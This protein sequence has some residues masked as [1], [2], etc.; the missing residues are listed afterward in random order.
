MGGKGTKQSNYRRYHPPSSPFHLVSGHVGINCGCTGTRK[1]S[2]H[3]RLSAPFPPP[4]LPP[5]HPNE[6][7]MRY[8]SGFAD[9]SPLKCLSIVSFCFIRLKTR[10]CRDAECY[11]KLTQQINGIDIRQRCINWTYDVWFIRLIW[12]ICIRTFAH[13][14]ACSTNG[15]DRH[16]SNVSV[17]F[18]CDGF[19]NG[20]R[21]CNC[22]Y[23]SCTW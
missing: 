8:R 5:Y 16:D 14:H 19:V 20:L 9:L 7:S 3:S 12:N 22:T 4:P 10:Y 21:T 6:M 23:I 1:Y 2:E 17:G 11:D 13:T 18:S 15:N